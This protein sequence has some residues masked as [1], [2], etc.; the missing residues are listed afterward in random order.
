MAI[1]ID[2][3]TFDFLTLRETRD[4]TVDVLGWNTYERGSVLEG[5]PRKVFLDAFDSE[6]Q[7]RAAYPHVR[8]FSSVLTEPQVFLRHLPSEDDF[9]AGGVYP[10]DI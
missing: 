4:C 10:D 6:A 9:V 5:Q 7:A 1:E 2:G 8:G 3:V